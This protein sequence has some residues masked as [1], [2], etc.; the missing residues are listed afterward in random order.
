MLALKQKKAEALTSKD[1]DSSHR[2]AY[3]WSYLVLFPTEINFAHIK[4]QTSSLVEH[5]FFTIEL[6]TVFSPRDLR[7]K[8][9][10]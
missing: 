5:D 9:T 8:R 3:I 10:P 2:L 4:K 1:T 7:A 6:L